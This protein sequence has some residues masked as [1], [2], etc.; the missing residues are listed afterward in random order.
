MDISVLMYYLQS[1]PLEEILP[2]YLKS[3]EMNTKV[4]GINLILNYISQFICKLS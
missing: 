1:L 3:D 2:N 4:K